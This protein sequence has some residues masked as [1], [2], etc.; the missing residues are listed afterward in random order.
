MDA[1][2]SGREVSPH[3]LDECPIDYPPKMT[4]TTY[5]KR[6]PKR[7]ATASRSLQIPN[8]HGKEPTMSIADRDYMKYEP[9][10]LVRF[11]RW[12][13]RRGVL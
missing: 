11:L 13:V 5:M 8:T 9:S 1:R 4:D 10:K 7:E 2:L 3:T 12:L 6:D